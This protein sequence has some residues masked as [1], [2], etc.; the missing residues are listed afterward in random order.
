MI[1]KNSN[2]DESVFKGDSV[3]VENSQIKQNSSLYRD[4]RVLNSFVG[5][6]CIIGDFARIINSSLSVYNKIDRSTLIYHSIIGDYTYF[7]TNDMVMHSELGKFCSV[8]W[9]VTVGAGNHDY[10]KISTHDFFYNDTYGIKP[11]G[12]SPAYDRYKNKTIIGNDVWIGANSTI[13]NGVKIGDGAVIGANSMV[14][15]NI[16]SYAIVAGN[17][18]KIL[19]F[20]F[21]DDIIEELTA[22]QWWNLPVDIL[23]DNYELLKSD[24][25]KDIITDLKKIKK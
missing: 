23:K 8:A 20:R 1:L 12:E 17:P 18:A 25:I 15:K 24:N 3:I 22:L 7:G 4:C 10:N 16:P 14:T 5:E 9:G 19:K 11:R 21:D 2:I 6:D 13:A